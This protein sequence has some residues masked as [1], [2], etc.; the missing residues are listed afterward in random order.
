MIEDEEGKAVYK[1]HEIGRVITNYFNKLYSTA[2]A[3]NS[4]DIVAQAL[5]PIISADVNE[6]LIKQPSPQEIGDAVFSIHADKAP[7][8]DGF[9]ASFF[10][11][12]WE[13]IGGEIV[14]EVQACFES[15]TLP[16]KI[17]DTHIRLIRKILSP[18]AVG[19]Y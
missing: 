14:A 12:N 13:A 4:D 9:S 17:N 11:S 7:G 5:R 16:P 1:E 8:L 6:V 10:Q 19:D 18:Q 2:G 15:H 3:S